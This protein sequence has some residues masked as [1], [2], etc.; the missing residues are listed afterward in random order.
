MPDHL[1]MDPISLLRLSS[2]PVRTRLLRD[3][4]LL[5]FMTA[6]LLAA[7]NIPLIDS[8]KEDLAESRIN[9]ATVSIR[10]EVMGLIT[11]VEQ[12][13]LIIRDGIASTGLT[14]LDEFELTK[15][16]VP[17]LAHMPQI[18]GVI[19]ATGEGTEYR[20]QRDGDHWQ[21]YVLNPQDPEQLR[22][23]RW[24]QALEPVE[25]EVLQSDRDPRLR[26]WF[27]MAETSPGVPVWTQPYLFS[28]TQSP[29]LT[30]ALAWQQD[31]L[32]RITAMDIA[33]DSIVKS[34][35]EHAI[36][37]DG[38][39][40]LFTNAGSIYLPP[41]P[42]EESP[43]AD[44][45]GF[46]SAHLTPDASLAI[47]AVAAWNQAGRPE[48]EL[49]RF[50]RDGVPWWGGFRPLTD[51]PTG[52]WVAVVLPVSR[53]L[54][55]LKNR[56]HLLALT[57][58]AIMLASLAMT[59]LLVRKYHRQLSDLPK[60]RIDRTKVASE[61]RELILSGEG[62]HLEF[63]ST[64]RMNLH[65]KTIGREIELAWLKAVAA[66]LNSEGGILL[67]GIADDGTAHGL[68]AD[69]F[70]NEDKCRLH[71]K[72]LFNQHL[73]PEYAR[74][75]RFELHDFEDVRIGVV[76][77]ERANTPVF[78][79]DDKRREWFLIRNGPSNTDLSISRALKYIRGRFG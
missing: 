35:E 33:M 1:L 58:V 12:Q 28:S 7:I 23:T 60:L 76:E 59:T 8:I 42:T 52:G 41:A 16:L 15:R 56:W 61:L 62:C 51:D 45:D 46:F 17:T 10:D 55:I 40:F 68:A 74:F 2:G 31:D 36:S 44:D 75:V 48:H 4:L 77:C 73:G 39:G 50:N 13:L 34:I 6:A 27:I 30:V 29:G 71:F 37:V 24:S 32:M 5:L 63:K 26:P 18:A 22:H 9:T 66:F 20:L 25:Q 57:V 69:L 38:R 65:S 3:L 43:P 72:N 78:L 11:P 64:M 19:D 79:L 47:D 54:A 49:V 21:T 53:T 14:P 70:E 67:L